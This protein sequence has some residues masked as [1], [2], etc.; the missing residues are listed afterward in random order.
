MTENPLD[1]NP[2]LKFGSEPG[3]DLLWRLWDDE[4]IV[5]DDRSGDTHLLQGLGAE[6]FLELLNGPVRLDELT[7]RTAAA[8]DFENDSQFQQYVEQTVA[9]FIRLHLL[10]AHPATTGAVAGSEHRF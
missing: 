1:N 7:E 5:Y 2:L 8:L 3:T 6:L 9:E 10:E 4:V